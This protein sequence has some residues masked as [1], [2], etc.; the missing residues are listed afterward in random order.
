MST[1]ATAYTESKKRRQQRSLD[2]WCKK[3][4]EQGIPEESEFVFRPLK[5]HLLQPPLLREDF[6]LVKAHGLPYGGVT[7]AKARNDRC[8]SVHTSVDLE[9]F[10]GKIS[11]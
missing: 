1:A 4:R 6:K 7:T 8:V 11:A 9:T 10:Y 2:W 5:V 3:R